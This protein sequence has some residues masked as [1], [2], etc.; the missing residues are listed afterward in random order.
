MLYP[1][2]FRICLAALVPLLTLPTVA[3]AQERRDLTKGNTLYV[4]PYSHLDTQWRWAYPQVIRE[5][6]PSTLHDNFALLDK[7]PSYIFNFSGSRRYEMMR[8]YYPADYERLKGYIRSGRWFPAG[9]SVDESD[10]NVPSGESLIRH[11]LYGNNFFRKEFGIASDEFMLPDCFGFPYALP[12]LLAHCGVK[13]FSTQKLTWGSAVGVPFKVGV[14]VGPDGRSVVA[15][16]DPGAYAAD[17]TEDLSENSSWLARIQSTGKLSGAYVDYHYYGTGDIGGAPTEESVKWVEKSMAGKGPVK[18]ISSKADEMFNTLTPEQISKL[19]KYQGE[20]LLTEHS[21]GSITSQ[22]YMKRWNRKN[23]LLADAAEKASVG[24]MVM[25]GAQYPAKRLYD[26]WDLVLG[27]QMHDMLPGTSVPKAYEYCWNDELLA[28]NQFAAVETDAV[29]S[30]AQMLDTRGEGIPIVVYNPLSIE[31]EDVVEVSVSLG[32]IRRLPS[33]KDSAGNVVPFQ[34]LPSAPERPRLIFKAKV[35]AL[36]FAVYH[37]RIEESRSYA[38][39]GPA[40]ALENKFL[41]VT[42]NEAGDIASIFDKKANREVLKSPSRLEL[43]YHNPR[44]FPAWNMDWED[45]KHPATE[46]VGGPAEIKKVENGPIRQAIE[47]TRTA[48]GSK[49]TQIIRLTAGSDQV[50]VLNKIDWQTRER[51]LK[52][53]FPL[54]TG[55]P[56]AT[57]DLQL[58]AIQRGNNDEKKYEVPQHQWLDLTS[59]DGSYGAAIL[60]DSK[61]GSDKPNDDTVRLTLLYTPGVRGGY[62]D[63]ATQDFGRHEITYVIAPHQGNWEKGDV[64]WKARRLNQPLHAFIAPKHNGP[65]GSSFSM[66]SLTSD[67]VEVQALKKA[68]EGNEV[69]VRLRELTGSPAKGIQLRFAKP[70]ISAREVDGQERTIGEAKVP[71]GVLETEVSAFSLRSFAVRFENVEPARNAGDMVSLQ[72]PY[73]TDVA[74]S[75]TDLTDGEFA[76]SKA[77]S[78]ELFPQAIE[79]DG[80]PFGFGR[81]EKGQKNAWTARGQTIQLP[82][83]FDRVHI[84]AAADADVNAEFKVGSEGVQKTIHSWD[85]FFGLWDNRLWARDPGPNFRN[86]GDWMSGL[87]PGFAKDAEVAWYASHNHTAQGN[88]F[89]EYSYL[90]KYSFDLPEGAETFTLPNDP[91]I[92]VFSLTASKGSFDEVVPA[93]PLYD[94]L[95][96]HKAGGAPTITPGGGSFNDVT[97][98]S[99]APPLYWKQGSLRYKIKTGDEWLPYTGPIRLNDPTTVNAAM[100]DDQGNMTYG[101]DAMLDVR[102]TTAPSVLDNGVVKALAHAK[103][104]F[105]EPVTR[106]SAEDVSH[107]ALSSGVKVVSAKLR[108]DERTVELVLDKPLSGPGLETLTVRGVNDMARKANATDLTVILQERGAV[109]NSPELEKATSRA[110]N[111]I[112]GLPVKSKDAWSMNVWAKVDKMP[113]P[114][115][116]IAGFGRSTDGRIGTGRY[117]SWFTR[118]INF[119]SSNRDIGSTTPLDLGKWQM[120]TA[121]YDGAI[122]RM[123]KNGELIAEGPT[124]LEDDVAQVRVMPLDAWD[125][126]RKFDGEVRDMTVWDVDLSPSAVKRLFG[127]GGGK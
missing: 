17:V 55:N 32:S 64:V 2:H 93:H 33:L 106:S 63:Q 69:I 18:V 94:T 56:L 100:F 68:E 10:A 24:A 14:W 83:G 105:S 52:A 46:V 80:L 103:V 73:D 123:Y 50:E 114:L 60:N 26:A 27:S 117:F 38:L 48:Q 122:L 119:W 107:Y 110:F 70:V 13:G 126:T 97:Y 39:L 41:K 72:R 116:L 98:V 75:D 37:V 30:I 91:R 104:V 8:E 102:D 125:R 111:D 45:A 54:T 86:Y 51:A 109:F 53:S 15:A 22:A 108:P 57:Y 96:E 7:Y 118:G 85:G 4:V 95:E 16:L 6:I 20:L 88:T 12:S 127:M 79:S 36:G 71:N 35:P 29:G 25:A 78:A 58:G 31:R 65:L 99:I 66:L 77:L 87:V 3:H 23:E 1:L 113:E 40:T 21:A 115:T 82:K 67:Q 112:R 62:E 11:V 34:I 74:S 44:A 90:Y 43:Q 124:Q 76:A 84:I 120:L 81:T 59:P 49:F 5:Y 19:P 92:K 9:S 61:Y 89:Y 101:S 121:T 28:L 47:V 42:L